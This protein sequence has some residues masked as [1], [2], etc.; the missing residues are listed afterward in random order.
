[1][2]KSGKFEAST[3]K[4]LMSWR[5]FFL[6]NLFQRG[7][8]VFR[9]IHWNFTTPNSSASPKKTTCEDL[10]A[11]KSCQLPIQDAFSW[12]RALNALAARMSFNTIFDVTPWNV[13]MSAMAKA[14]QWQQA[15]WL[16]GRL[17]VST[18]KTEWGDDA[19][20]C[21]GAIARLGQ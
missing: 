16:F 15:L 14:T 12:Q 1:M 7:K 21:W 5:N 2:A 9:K 10:A 4:V 11:H 8:T 3:A 13:V 19:C 17:F 18:S 20:G 6:G